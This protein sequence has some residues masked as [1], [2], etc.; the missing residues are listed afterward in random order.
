[1][2]THLSATVYLSLGVVCK[3]QEEIREAGSGRGDQMEIF[4]KHQYLSQKAIRGQNSL[5]MVSLRNYDSSRQGTLSS[6]A[7]FPLGPLLDLSYHGFW[8]VCRG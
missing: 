7:S 8:E 4:L 1:M 3:T 5:Q 6:V 2:P